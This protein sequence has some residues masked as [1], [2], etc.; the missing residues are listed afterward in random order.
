MIKSGFT[1]RTHHVD[2][3][4]N[5]LDEDLFTVAVAEQPD[6]AGRQL[7]ITAADDDEDDPDEMAS[8]CVVDETHCTSYGGV[9]RADLADGVVTLE[10][11]DRAVKQLE[12]AGPVVELRLE[13][14]PDAV[15][16][17]AEGMREVFISGPER[18]RPVLGGDLA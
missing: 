3:D 18:F 1:V 7:L 14:E 17:L 6:G 8:Y 11:S 12:L 9:R 15:V 16:S 4:D 13:L 5:Y 2:A 10:F